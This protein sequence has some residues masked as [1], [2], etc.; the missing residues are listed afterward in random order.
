MLCASCSHPHRHY[1]TPPPN[2]CTR[3][4]AASYGCDKPCKQS[5]KAKWHLGEAACAAAEGVS[6]LSPYE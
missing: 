6:T 5:N 3:S 4:W 1:V 2:A